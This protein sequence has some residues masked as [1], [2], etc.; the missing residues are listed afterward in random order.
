[1]LSTHV[2]CDV[3]YSRLPQCCLL[4]KSQRLVLFCMLGIAV[5]MAFR[6]LNIRFSV[7]KDAHKGCVL[8]RWRMNALRLVCVKE[9]G[10]LN[11]RGSSG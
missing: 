9:I 3:V 2:Y 1:M 10:F 5:L 4:K 6:E 7:I 8:G 11:E